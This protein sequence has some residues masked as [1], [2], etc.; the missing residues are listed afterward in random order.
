V[1]RWLVVPAA[2]R[3]V[4]VGVVLALV[5]AG[6]IVAARRV[7]ADTL[8]AAPPAAGPVTPVLSARRVPG[9]LVAPVA[10]ARLR[11]KLDAFLAAAHG[12]VCL[13]VSN[14]GRPIYSHQADVPLAPASLVKLLTATA[15]LDAL[16]ADATYTTAVEAAAAPQAGV[17]GGD[18]WLVGSGDPLLE[19][20]AYEQ[21]FEHQPQVRTDF[22]ALADAVK[23]AGITKV[24]GRVIGDETRYD[25]DRYVDAWPPRYI[26]QDQTGPLSAL[27]VDDGFTAFPPN[28]DVRE[29]DET[30]AADPPAYAAALLTNLLVARG[31]TVGGTA[32]AGAAPPGAVTVAHVQSPI[33]GDVVGEMLRESDNQTAELLTKELGTKPGAPGNTA[34]GTAALSDRLNRMA[35][36]TTGLTLVDGSGLAT[37]D[38]GTCA[39]FQAVLDRAGPT[40][41]IATGLP[42]AGQTGTLD[43]RFVG[44]PAAGRLR[45]KT[46]T[47]NQ[48]TALAGYVDT[49]IGAPLSFTYIVNLPADERVSVDDLALQDQLVSILLGYPEGPPLD[50]VGP[51]P[52]P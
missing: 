28:P 5:C 24:T 13:T 38:R 42:V 7:D 11:T 52:V 1:S 15:A 3:R 9:L 23:A 2:T 33:L 35:L 41:P 20:D 16:G 8:S 43:K 30:P 18:L 17:V 21:H 36:P 44:T 39:L 25:A 51:K 29:P 27:D 40:S 48:V 12:S 32:A 10:D 45:A 19:T 4:V 6:S 46:G 37:E 50:Q 34:A 14:A 49:L 31:V 26:D 22:E 47:L